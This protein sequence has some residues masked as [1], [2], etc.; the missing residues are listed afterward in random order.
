VPAA[1]A[2][3]RNALSAALRNGGADRAPANTSPEPKASVWFEGGGPHLSPGGT[4]MAV[5]P[6][7]HLHDARARH[8]SSMA[9]HRASGRDATLMRALA[10]RRRLGALT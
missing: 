7:P 3:A 4:V 5:V 2:L 9:S 8:V 10:D 1:S 6:P